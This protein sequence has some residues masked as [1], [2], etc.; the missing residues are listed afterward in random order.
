MKVKFKSTIILGAVTITFIPLVLSYIIFVSSKISDTHQEIKNTLKEIGNIIS[1]NE[2]VKE[3]LYSRDNDKSIQE[4]S[5][6]FIENFNDVDIIVVGDMTGEKYSHLDETQIGEIYVNDDNIDVI[7]KGIRYYSTME[8]SMGI[9]LR[10]FEPI[11]YNNQQ[12]GFVMV[13]KYEKDIDII[14]SKTK[15]TYSLLFIF[16]ISLSIIGAKILADKTKKSILNMEPV[17]IAALYREKNIIIDSVN[18]G[19][20]SLNKNKKIVEVNEACYKL[21]D[22]FKVDD[23]LEKINVYIDNKEEVEMKEFVIKG[24]KIFVT[25]KNIK[26]GNNCLRTII[27]L[28]DKNPINKIAKEITG[29]DEI[30]KNLRANIHEFKNSLYVILGLLEINAYDDAKK[31]ILKTQ[32]LQENAINKFASIE[33]KYVRGLLISRELVA[34]ERKIDFLLTE[35]SFLEENHGII[36]PNDIVTIL[37]NLI[38]NAFEACSLCENIKKRVEVSLYEDESV[39]EIQ[40]RD[41]GKNIDREIRDT[42]FSEGISSKGE[43]RGTG[44]YLVKNRVEIYNGSID[45]EEF[46]DEKIF[47]VTIL[48]GEE[49]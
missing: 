9:T 4:Y 1:K 39:I 6:I 37:G 34:K 25:I 19:I 18:D 26:L 16:S 30:I 23:I 24:K 35:E 15:F 31:Y 12:V 38:E 8:G 49:R 20:I 11:F 29:V 7:N 36:D 45:I 41:N 32:N 42:L 17:E 10:W 22:D 46:G 43:G 40:V 13:G 33:D 47:V 5:K 3:K 28:V 44:L 14:T 2:V 27:T 48:K 21:F